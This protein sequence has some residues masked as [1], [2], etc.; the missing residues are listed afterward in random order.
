[1]RSGFGMA[2]TIRSTT[3]PSRI[4]S[5]V[6][7][8]R[9]SWRMASCW[10][11]STLTLTTFNRPASSR[12]SSSRIGPTNRHGPHQGA[13][14]STTTVGAARVS[15][16]NVP[17]RRHQPGQWLA[18]CAAMRRAARARRDPVR[19]PAVRAPEDRDRAGGGCAAWR[20]RRSRSVV[21][22]GRARRTARARASD[23]NGLAGR[24]PAWRIR[25][26]VTAS[27]A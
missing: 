10:F 14:R 15:S 2:P 19:G 25:R 24:H 23:V 22:L 1:M 7:M 12:E 17:R 5:M 11:S 16:S 13:Q 21:V 26:P 20:C 4:T 8:L 6:G 3:A 18:A 27:S 9:A